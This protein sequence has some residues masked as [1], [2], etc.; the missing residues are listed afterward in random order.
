VPN[1]NLIATTRTKPPYKVK[2]YIY[3]FSLVADL[4]AKVLRQD[5]PVVIWLRFLAN[6]KPPLPCEWLHKYRPPREDC[7]LHQMMTADVHQIFQF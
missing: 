4:G 2:T 3:F 5:Q 7:G 6:P 1:P